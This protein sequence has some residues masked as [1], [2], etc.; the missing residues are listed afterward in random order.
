M[1]QENLFSRLRR[2]ANKV[3]NESNLFQER[4]QK[5]PDQR[6]ASD[7][8]ANN[9]L[10]EMQYDV[11]RLKND[12]SKELTKQKE[13]NSFQD[14]LAACDNLVRVNQRQASSLKEYLIQYGYQPINQ[15]T[16][17]TTK[18]KS[19]SDDKENALGDDVAAVGDDQV[20]NKGPCTPPKD[21]ASSSKVDGDKTPK[22]ED[23]GL[24]MNRVNIFL[25]KDGPTSSQKNADVPD[26]ERY[27]PF[28]A[29]AVYQHSGNSNFNDSELNLSNEP[30]APLLSS[31][32]QHPHISQNLYLQHGDHSRCDSVE[33]QSPNITS[34]FLQEPSKPPVQPVISLQAEPFTPPTPDCQATEMLSVM[35]EEP[36]RS[37]VTAEKTEPKEPVQNYPKVEN[38]TPEL[39][40][41]L[42]DYRGN[43]SSQQDMATP[44][45]TKA[46]PSRLAFLQAEQG[47]PR[48]PELTMSLSQVHS[49]P[50]PNVRVDLPVS[51]V[52]GNYGQAN[53]AADLQT[54]TRQE[55]H[56]QSISSCEHIAPITEQ[57]FSSLSSK[58][59]QNLSIERVNGWIKIM[60]NYL[61]EKPMGEKMLCSE[62]LE[63]LQG[64]PWLRA[65]LMLMV[66]FQRMERRADGDDV[67]FIP[68]SMNL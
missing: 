2:L 23:F 21:E 13:A 27:T 45:H 46:M 54:P 36:M 5:P 17:L 14:V 64:Y 11:H 57:E 18:K 8:T 59:K 4:M 12:A 63:S 39:P 20:Q 3:E 19:S 28:E 49:R 43:L 15:E 48:T 58:M 6:V 60:D 47:T 42:S 41:C 65:L 38:I 7:A 62:D 31:R 35:P 68:S 61:A 37:M 1:D 56:P 22:M 44:V 52:R 55:M 29:T 16:K 66:N 26:P 40:P 33:P 32:K 51:Q 50:V 53:V 34:W 67:I 30:Q 9:I 10:K 25:K 24:S